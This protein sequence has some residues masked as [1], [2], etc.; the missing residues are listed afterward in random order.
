[1][2]PG[3]VKRHPATLMQKISEPAATEILY[4]RFHISHIEQLLF[5]KPGD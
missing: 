3:G 5:N 1:M 2:I 4:L